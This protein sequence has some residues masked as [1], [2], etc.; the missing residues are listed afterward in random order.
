VVI[1]DVDPAGADLAAEIGARARFVPTDVS[2]RAAVDRLVSA[3]EEAFGAPGI[4]VASAAILGEEHPVADVPADAWDRVLAINLTGVLHCCQAVLPGMVAQRWG[5]IVVLTS[6]ARYGVP[7]R[8]PYAVTKAGVTALMGSIGYAHAKDGV[9]A[10]SVDPGR[11]LTNM[12]VP[13]YD[14]EYLASPPGVATGRMAR[15]E[16]IAEVI[17]F[18]ASERN[19]YAVGAIWEATGGLEWG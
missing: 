10:N 4:L 1:A 2:D 5:R 11:A 7:E 12:I 17:A 13:R 14:P 3:A 9:L 15:P 19:T 6:H 8:A 18:L 16:E